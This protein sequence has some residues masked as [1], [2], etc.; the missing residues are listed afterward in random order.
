MLPVSATHIPLARGPPKRKSN[1]P[2]ADL[3]GPALGRLNNPL[4][5]SDL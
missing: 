2:R 5:F 4:F 1:Y 3:S